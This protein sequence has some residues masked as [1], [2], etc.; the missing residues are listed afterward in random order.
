MSIQKYFSPQRF[1]NYF[2][3]DLRLNV[4]TY[5]FFCVGIAIILFCANFFALNQTSTSRGF[6][7]R[8]YQPLFFVTFTLC[9]IVAIGTSFPSLRNKKDSSHYLLLPASVFEKFL[10]Q[11]LI[12]IVVFTA[13][14][15]ILF[16][17]EFKFTT[18]IY[19]S[20]EWKNTLTVKSFDLAT[21]FSDLTRTLDLLAVLFGIFS[22]ATFLLM[23]AAYFKK[24]ALFKTILAFGL[25]IGLF[26]LTMV[27]GSHM[28][29]PE[30]T[31]EFFSIKID[32]YKI[33]ENLHN[34]Q[35]YI[36]IVVTAASLFFLPITY[37]KLKEKQV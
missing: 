33:S 27:V 26:F 19:Q 10:T 13:F 14:F 16:W 30:K 12:R 23:G 32:T 34:V 3:Y 21:P 35:M 5:L 15:Y 7:K 9:S 29:Y 6:L 18:A 36:Y 2:K 31:Q 8:D 11:F 17:L 28:F 1:I 20:I 4:K 24:Y 22:I 25:L 37:F